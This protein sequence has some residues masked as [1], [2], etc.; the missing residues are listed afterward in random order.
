MSSM[1]APLTKVDWVSLG[2]H[3][4]TGLFLG[5]LME[6]MALGYT[7]A[8]VSLPPSHIPA[9]RNWTN[10]S[11]YIT[12]KR[13]RQPK[14]LEQA[15]IYGAGLLGAYESQRKDIPGPDLDVFSLSTHSIQACIHCNMVYQNGLN[16][17]LQ[18]RRMALDDDWQ[19]KS[20]WITS[21]LVWLTGAGLYVGFW[22]QVPGVTGFPE[23]FSKVK[24][25]LYA[26]YGLNLAAQVA[27]S[28][29]SVVSVY[30]K[31]KEA[32][33][34]G[35][36][37]TTVILY[38]KHVMVVPLVLAV[39]SLVCFVTLPGRNLELV[40]FLPFS[41]AS[42]GSVIS[43]LNGTATSIM[44]NQDSTSYPASSPISSFGSGGTA[45]HKKTASMTRVV[46]PVERVEVVQ[47]SDKDSGYSPKTGLNRLP[48][49]S[50]KSTVCQDAYEENEK[51]SLNRI[52]VPSL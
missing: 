6:L 26:H 2:Q 29:T 43:I 49:N 48:Y 27:L 18:I 8:L 9:K 51:V 45:Q 46:I 28:V 33:A 21:S 32:F 22:R 12:L 3:Y 16:N 24:P 39:V 52:R 30:R 44:H 14:M 5:N 1:E 23:S 19:M 10:I 15:A 42:L 11:R 50:S 47:I 7:M 25:L 31:R 40:A 17:Y 4:R 13:Y 37:M 35:T 36:L 38:F 20:I 34:H 41:A